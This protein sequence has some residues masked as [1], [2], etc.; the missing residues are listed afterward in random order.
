MTLKVR[1]HHGHK[2]DAPA[3]TEREVICPLCGAVT[4]FQRMVE[5]KGSSGVDQTINLPD[6]GQAETFQDE[7]I[8]ETLENHLQELV[9]DDGLH[10]IA[11]QESSDSET[12][13]SG[14]ASDAP[15]AKTV[16]SDQTVEFDAPLPEV[17]GEVVSGEEDDAIAQTLSLGETVEVHGPIGEEDGHDASEGCTRTTVSDKTVEMD[18]A[19]SDTKSSQVVSGTVGT[20]ST[21]TA[22]GGPIAPT[23]L[24]AT[25]DGQN[26][27]VVEGKG[28]PPPTPAKPVLEDD[29]ELE[30]PKLPGY[31][32]VSELGRGG[33][34]VVYRAKHEKLN[35]EVA[36]KTLLHISPVELQRFKAEF[37]SLAD[38]AHPN[39]AGLYELLSDGQ[40][41]CFSMEIL[42]AVDFTEYVWSGF[43][44]LRR[45]KT[46][47]LMGAATEAAPRLSREIKERLFEG[48][49]QLAYGLNTLHQAGMLHRD[50]KPSNVLV[51]TEG[52]VVLVDFG[53]ASQFE[54]GSKDRPT[55]IQGTPQYMAPEQA[56]CDPI[57]PASDWYAVGVMVY[58]VLTGYWPIQGK[59]ISIIF[60]KQTDTPK[61]PRE[62]NPLV[63]QHLNDLCVALLDR[64]PNQR[65]TAIDILRCIG[66]EDVIESMKTSPLVGG[67][68]T[69]ELVGR[70]GHLQGLMASFRQVIGGMTKTLFVHGHSGMG[71]SVLI[72]KFIAEV[73]EQDTAVVL[74]G[75]CYEQESVPFKALDS[76]IDSLADHLTGL[77][78]PEV[79]AATPDDL[80]PLIRLFPVLGQIP[81]ASDAGRPSI[82]NVDQQ[83]IRQRAM[84][85]L[86]ELLKRLGEQKPL[87]LYIDDLQ[88]GDED[89]A[90][91]LA[92]LVRPPNAPRTLVLGS[93]RTENRD[94]SFCLKALDNAYSTGQHR[95][96]REEIAV[97]SLQQEDAKRL[98]LMLLNRDD[99]GGDKLATK[100]ARESKGWPF[101]VWELAQHVQDSPEIA[102]QSLELDEVIW[103]RVNRLPE[104][105][106]HLLEL[107]A[108]TGRPIPAVEAYQ[109]IG[110]VE[111][112]QSL[113]AQ[114]RTRNLIRTTESE[115]EDTAIE[116]YHDRIRESVVAHLDAGV[117]KGHNL[118]LALTMETASGLQVDDLWSHIRSRAEFDEPTEA[119]SLDKRQWQRVFDLATFFAAADKHERA[120]PFA[121][122]AAE[123][124][125]VQNAL[126]VA[127]Q[128]YRIALVGA[129]AAAIRFR[130]AEGLADVLML[131]GKYDEAEPQLQSAHSMAEGS[132]AIARVEGKLGALK[133]KKGE[134]AEAADHLERALTQLGN[135]PPGNSI[136]QVALLLKE[137]VVQMLHTFFPSRFVGVQPGDTDR[138]KIDLFCARLYDRVSYAY[139]YTRGTLPTMWAHLRQLNLAERY[140]ASP[141][142][143]QAC[144][145]HSIIMTAIPYPARG[146]EY[147]EKSF[148]MR[149]QL[150]D[151]WGQGQSR[152][153]Q[154][155]SCIVDEQFERGCACGEQAVDLLEKA[156]D[157]WEANMARMMHAWSLYFLG[158]L[159]GVL[160]AAKKGYEIGFETG[161][162]S[163][164]AVAL[165][166][167]VRITDAPEDAIR[168]EVDRQRTDPL[169][170]AI[171][172]QARGLELLLRKNSPVE[173]AKVFQDSLDLAKRRGIRNPLVFS[174][175]SFKATAL[176]VAAEQAAEGPKRTRAIK[177]AKRAVRTALSLTKGYRNCRSQA[178]REAGLLAALEGKQEQARRFLD[179]SIAVAERQGARYHHAQSLVA[180][181]E[182]G[183]KFGWPG[184]EDKLIEARAAINELEEFDETEE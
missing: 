179:E 118:Q 22:G 41:W 79:R 125:K 5:T 82:E 127:E 172:I 131:R 28:T 175:T 177:L 47:R 93:Y 30:P 89:S 42:E 72:Q 71:K 20:A 52:R 33:M 73:R 111:R 180:R 96:H 170:A 53:L 24:L 106:R 35:R 162:Y 55:G 2:F 102:D 48:L 144:S 9:T 174:S 77:T 75:R 171:A 168:C 1:C 58:E 10:T 6:S 13:T 133:F 158:D 91:L 94:T 165:G 27:A 92:D 105:T 167:W 110:A 135:R 11:F 124:A 164:M 15:G 87:V 154:T 139:W 151:L 83:E 7:I 43:E 117:V 122:C 64:D 115:D 143:A 39:L 95:P 60:K 76:L 132:T 80:L 129:A 153:F 109:A 98:A 173:A 45:S 37:R 157:V 49:K 23:A 65:P 78:E 74:T 57:S 140:P 3:H 166:F 147:A 137:S 70:E 4:R 161:D 160:R 51:T 81:G 146:I 119:Y 19:S 104:E 50:I 108:V 152:S 142:L 63:P 69:L 62:L 134:M 150:G 148:E 116:S 178:L 128:Q 114:L 54:E 88:W 46:Q 163:T 101:F 34:G 107:I 84:N 99:E 138:A 18:V 156:G 38:I 25:L 136:I 149:R 123:Q 86:R 184:A 56:A 183:V 169:C 17:E 32:V 8:L 176:R 159:Q 120:L 182:V 155:F 112:G 26:Q 121:I 14:T 100:I 21:P 85:A 126:E 12:Q 61:A 40:T 44:A 181:G 31:T 36:L 59:P 141:E 16:A 130:I 90:D 145:F 67:G 103:T 97:D 113:L 68:Q 66:A 29:S